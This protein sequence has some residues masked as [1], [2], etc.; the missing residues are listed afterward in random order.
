MG[1]FTKG[2][3]AGALISTAVGIMVM[4]NL[5]RRTQRK[6]KKAG[7]KMRDM[8]EDTYESMMGCCMK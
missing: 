4:P 6:M 5:D 3:V 2:I 7:M 1:N 8:A